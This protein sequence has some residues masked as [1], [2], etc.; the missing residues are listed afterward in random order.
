MPHIIPIGMSVICIMAL[1]HG[2]RKPA[3]G[4][5]PPLASMSTTVVRW[6]IDAV[7]AEHIILNNLLSRQ[8]RPLG[9]MGFQV[10]DP[11]R[12]L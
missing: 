2:S 1:V 4:D 11:Q 7:S 5:G 8:Q 10:N 6:R 3:I 9:K 12:A